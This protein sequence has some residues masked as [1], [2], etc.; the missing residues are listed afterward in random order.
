MQDKEVSPVVSLGF[1]C[2]GFTLDPKPCWIYNKYVAFGRGRA[3]LG[4]INGRLLEITHKSSCF[5]PKSLGD[6]RDPVSEDKIRS[7]P[8]LPD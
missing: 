4:G 3:G 2:S 5:Y 8:C 7:S 6:F 1:V